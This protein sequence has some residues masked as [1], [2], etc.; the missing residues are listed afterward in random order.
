MAD[1]FA[2]WL[3]LGKGRESFPK[4]F[5]VNWFRTSDTG[6]H[7]WPGFGDN[8]RVLQWIHGRVHGKAEGRESAI[9]IL[10]A[11]RAIH[12]E[13]LNLLPGAMSELFAIDRAEWLEEARDQ[14][15]FLKSFGDRTPEGLWRQ[16][17][18]LKARLSG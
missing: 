1:Y 8:L 18:Q 7:L 15:E 10:P 16:N 9:G 12:T 4:I 3:E 6:K 14:E 17:R 11:E 13:G 5:H 2:H